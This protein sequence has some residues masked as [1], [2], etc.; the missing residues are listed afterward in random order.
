[1]QAYLDY[2]AATPVAPEV[3]EAMLPYLTE[4]FHNP[5]APYALARSVRADFEAARAT[6]ARLKSRCVVVCADGG[7][8]L[9]EVLAA[10]GGAK[11]VAQKVNK[12]VS[13]AALPELRVPVEVVEGGPAFA[14][15]AAVRPRRVGR[16]PA[17]V[18]DAVLDE[19]VARTPRRLRPE[20][21]ENARTRCEKT[22]TGVRLARDGKTIWNF[23]IDTPEGRPFLHPMNLPSGAPLTDIRPKG[24]TF[25]YFDGLDRD[26]P[27][28]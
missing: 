13:T 3:L 8:V 26:H 23:E 1:M 6:L 7:A 16:F 24:D 17:S 14:A 22:A 10:P 21:I 18:I 9:R 5:S 20:V 4:R 27:V 15:F 11:L 12:V 25:Y 19:L 28:F 2:G